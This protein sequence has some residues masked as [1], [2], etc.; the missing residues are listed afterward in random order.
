M[1]PG[2]SKRRSPFSSYPADK[3]KATV[4]VDKVEYDSKVMAML[5]DEKTYGKLNKDPTQ[6]YKRKL[7]GILSDLKKCSKISD[8][9]YHYLYPTAE[10]I[11]SL[12]CIPKIHKDGN[13]LRP[14][15]TTLD[16]LAATHL[17]PLQIYYS[18][19]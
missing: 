8:S 17:E 11:P 10:K 6:V 1:Q 2:A 9:Q 16:Q 5:S 18:P 3:G 15:W 19:W 12:Y 14:I 13:P 7:V 4:L